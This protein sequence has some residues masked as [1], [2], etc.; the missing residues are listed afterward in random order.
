LTGVDGGDPTATTGVSA[1]FPLPLFALAGV[2][3]FGVVAFLPLLGLT[4]DA[5]LGVSTLGD[6]TLTGVTI[7]GVSTTFPFLPPLRFTGV[8]VFCFGV[9]TAGLGVSIF[10]AALPLPLLPFTGV[11]LGVAAFGV[12]TLGVAAFGVT[13][14]GVSC[15]GL[16]LR[17]FTGV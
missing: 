13:A 5:G 1:A 12:T 3:I 10:A 17:A 7:L 16:P 8:G 4:A 6:A 15:F 14:F 11:A 2:L 9:S